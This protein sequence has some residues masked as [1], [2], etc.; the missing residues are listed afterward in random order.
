MN[1]RAARKTESSLGGSAKK[2]AEK[3]KR[4]PFS[5]LFPMRD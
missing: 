2:S 4:E 1:S 3:R 5:L